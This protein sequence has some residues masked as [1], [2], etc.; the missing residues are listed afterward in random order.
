MAKRHFKVKRGLAVNT[1][2]PQ[3]TVHFDT[4]DAVRV[5]SGNSSHRP[6]GNGGMFRFSTDEGDF[7][8]YSND[9]GKIRKA[10]NASEVDFSPA[11]NIASDNV[12][13]AIEELD[14]EKS[15]HINESANEFSF[16]PAGDLSSD[17]L[18]D[19][20]EELDSGKSNLSTILSEGGVSS[21][22]QS[23]TDLALQLAV[24]RG[25]SFS[26]SQGVTDGFADMSDVDEANST[27]E[28][29]NSSTEQ[30]KLDPGANLFSVN[31]GADTDPNAAG[32]SLLFQTTGT[33]PDTEDILRMY[34]L[35]RTTTNLFQYV[36][37]EE[38]SNISSASY[39]DK[40]YD[41]NEV[42]DPRGFDFKADGEKL[43]AVD[44]DTKSVYQYTLSTPWDISMASYD[45]K[46]LDVGNTVSTDNVHGLTLRDDGSMLYVLGSNSTSHYVFQYSMSTP[47]DVSTAALDDFNSLADSPRGTF[48]KPDGTKMFTI[49]STN[50]QVR[51]YSLSTPW[52]VNSASFET[53]FDVSG[54]ET[55]PTGLAFQPTGE[56]F[57]II[58]LPEGVV[59]QYFMSETWNVASAVYTNKSYEVPQDSQADDV[60]LVMTQNDITVNTTVEAND[61]TFRMSRNP[62]DWVLAPGP[63]E[64]ESYSNATLV[65]S[66]NIDLSGEVSNNQMRWWIENNSDKTIWL[67]AVV[68]SW[69]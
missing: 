46:S 60:H 22:R 57:Y 54:E 3:V 59:Y 37:E 55:G 10:K 51:E 19:A 6:S 52:A 36:V 47:W 43:Y 40:T 39:D 69:E 41:L 26:L 7:E 61:F 17:D 31:F 56:R 67:D 66:L 24:L 29:H 30:V 50:D 20:I 13:G 9:W 23:I 33:E 53:S 63:T 48:F 58:G 12:Q 5:P 14:S 62:G 21:I 32:L 38:W 65:E 4:E 45:S 18:Q 2:S 64:V 28:T 42:P 35:G 15:D 49:V 27:G 44:D 1:S 34:V 68:I 25:H 8:G 11:G 16:S